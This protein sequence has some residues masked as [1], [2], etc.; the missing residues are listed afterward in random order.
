M[1]VVRRETPRQCEAGV[2]LRARGEQDLER[3]VVLLEERAKIL[4][5]PVV[6]PVQRLEHADRLGR[7]RLRRAGAKP[8]LH[9][10][11]GEKAINPGTGGQP[12]KRP[13]EPVHG[14]GR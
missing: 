9:G 10:G 2:V 8:A 6:E 13:G 14:G 7:R 12:D 1:R 11:G 3:R 4:L 5:Q